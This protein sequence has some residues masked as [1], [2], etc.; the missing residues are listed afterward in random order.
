MKARTSSSASRPGHALADEDERPL[1]PLEQVER[2]LD[3]LRRRHHARRVGRTLDLDDFVLVA[4]AGDDVV[5]HVEIGGAGAAIGRVPGRHLD[6][7]GDALHAIDAVGEFAERRGDQHLALFLECAHAAAIGLRGAAD[8]DHRPAILLGIGEAGETVHHAGAG[9]DDA[10]AG[11]A[12]QIAV[13]L[14]RVGGGLLVAHAD[15]GDAF[16]L[17]GRGDRADRKPD[18][19][20]QVIDALLFEAPRYQ[21]SAV[22]FAHAFLLTERLAL[23]DYALMAGPGK[24]VGHQKRLFAPRTPPRRRGR[25]MAAT[26]KLGVLRLCAKADPR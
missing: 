18:D 5:G 19:P 24:G 6:I 8:Q 25:R 1:G 26:R 17:R 12:G 21:G 22:D 20:E 4:L 11:P 7:I 13:G 16:L 10:G 9:H 15:I 2:R 23:R 14:R 3:V